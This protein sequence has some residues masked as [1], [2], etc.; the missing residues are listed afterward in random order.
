MHGICL[1]ACT[2]ILTLVHGH[3]HDMRMTVI[4]LRSA[5]LR[6]I[7]RLSDVNSLTGGKMTSKAAVS[8]F[9]AQIK[10]EN[11]L[12]VCFERKKTKKT[13]QS[14]PSLILSFGPAYGLF[15][16]FLCFKQTEQ[17]FSCFI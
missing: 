15:C 6:R 10:E 1:F 9:F 7:S 2:E 12:F 3:V 8:L 14:C 17:L 11:N 13:S 5:T 16:L 4:S